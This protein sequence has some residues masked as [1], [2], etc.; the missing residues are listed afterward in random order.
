M[1]PKGRWPATHVTLKKLYEERVPEGMS[2]EEFGATY[3]I[4][5]QGMVWQYL[6]GYRPVGIE[7]AAKFATGLRC[8]IADISP[9]MARAIRSE[10]YPVLGRIASKAAMLILL[11][12]PPLLPSKTEAGVI[13]SAYAEAVYYV[14]SM[15]R[16]TILRLLSKLR[17]KCAVS[18]NGSIIPDCQS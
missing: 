16:R 17:A 18:L 9:E 1:K 2:Q 14:K 4:G 15:L 6:N 3:G 12:V 5:T 11:V 13:F 8:T 10:I 7:V